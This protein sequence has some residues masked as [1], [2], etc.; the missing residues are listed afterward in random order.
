MLWGPTMVPFCCFAPLNCVSLLLPIHSMAGNNP[1]ITLRYAAERLGFVHNM[2]F[3]EKTIGGTMGLLR[4]LGLDEGQ[5]VRV[6]G[7]PVL[8]RCA[9]LVG[10]RMVGIF[11]WAVCGLL[12]RR[13]ASCVGDAGRRLVLWGLWLWPPAASRKMTRLAAGVHGRGSSPGGPL[14]PH[15][16]SSVVCACGG[17]LACLRWRES[18]GCPV[19]GGMAERAPP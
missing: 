18:A 12:G 13:F 19:A 17:L 10:G 3:F 6:V 9:L 5:S 11:G 14:A 1:S 15:G 8:A 4:V 7:A 2:I 16:R